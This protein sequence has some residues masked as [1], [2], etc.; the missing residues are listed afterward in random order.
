MYDELKEISDFTLLF[1]ETLNRTNQKKQMDIH[2]RY[3]DA[4]DNQVVTQYLTSVFMGHAT[5]ANIFESFQEAVQKL[6]LK[7]LLQISMDG[8]AVN[9][10]FYDRLQSEFKKRIQH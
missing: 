2:I 5:A 9:W 7:K 8:P 4:H 6:E 1:D 10:S 3:L